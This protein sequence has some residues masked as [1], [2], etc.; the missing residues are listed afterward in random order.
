MVGRRLSESVSLQDPLKTFDMKYILLLFY[1]CL[2]SHTVQAHYPLANGTV[3]C[4]TGDCD[5]TK[6]L[7]K[8]LK[9][10]EG[11]KLREYL[12]ELPR[13]DRDRFVVAYKAL[14]DFPVEVRTNVENLNLLTSKPIFGR[15]EISS[16]SGYS[17]DISEIIAKKGLS[18][19]EYLEIKVQSYDDLSI[20][21]KVIINEIRD[22]IAVPTPTTILQKAVDQNQI[23]RY[24]SG[25]FKQ[26][27]GFITTA[28]DS[29]HLQTYEDL[30]YGLRLDYI[31][32]PYKL[33]DSKCGIIR[34]TSND[35]STAIVPRSVTNG[36]TETLPM[37]FT[38]H[39]F[40]SG[41]NGRLGVPEWKTDY[42]SPNNGAEI[43]EVNSDGSE[44]LVA[45]F[46]SD[47]KQFVK[48]PEL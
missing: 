13:A 3:W 15:S 10:P 30:Y 20:D 31:D 19:D 45:V 48:V 6:L 29:K 7:A 34:Y 47:A 37:P 27:G 46:L 8:D 4:L 12:S 28:K 26:V 16:I 33:E 36:G 1:L 41:S 32:S 21:Q 40:T 14:G 23:D 39:G 24:L 2:V 18:Y 44:R 25:E 38:G 22:G 9:T 17:D 42:L 11:R 43:W 35:A 5:L